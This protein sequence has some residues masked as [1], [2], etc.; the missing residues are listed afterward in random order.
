LEGELGN[1][2]RL[3]EDGRRS[4]NPRASQPAINRELE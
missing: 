3:G 4:V 1:D 2:S